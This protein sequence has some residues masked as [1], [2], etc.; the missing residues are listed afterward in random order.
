[1]RRVDRVIAKT[2]ITF[3]RSD[4]IQNRT[5]VASSNSV[6][7]RVVCPNILISLMMTHGSCSFS[8]TF[9]DRMASFR[10]WPFYTTWVYTFHTLQTLGIKLFIHFQMTSPISCLPLP[11]SYGTRAINSNALNEEGQMFLFTNVSKSSIGQIW[12]DI[13]QERN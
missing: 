7:F 11:T 9:V 5:Y 4:Q 13:A 12:C 8:K 1:M 6:N 10:L 3:L 2:K